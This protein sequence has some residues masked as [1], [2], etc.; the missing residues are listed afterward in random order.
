MQRPLKDY[1]RSIGWNEKISAEA[2]ASFDISTDDVPE[3]F[4]L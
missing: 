1:V 2:K 4:S 3:L